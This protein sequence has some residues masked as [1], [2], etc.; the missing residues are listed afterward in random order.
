[1]RNEGTVI[2]SFVLPHLRRLVSF[3]V[4]FLFCLTDRKLLRLPQSRR[5]WLPR[6]LLA[7]WGGAVEYGTW[8]VLGTGKDVWGK[9]MGCQ[10]GFLFLCATDYILF[11][12]FPW[13]LRFSF[14][15]SAVRRRFKD[16]TFILKSPIFICGRIKNTAV[17]FF[18]FFCVCS[19]QNIFFIF[20]C[21]T[22]TGC[23]RRKVLLVTRF[24][25]NE[26]R[27]GVWSRIIYCAMHSK[28]PSQAIV[29][30]LAKFLIYGG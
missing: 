1:M 29:L 14:L 11:L 26:H 10:N 6:F 24:D 28:D 8:A 4:L 15:N 30:A 16:D 17:C 13:V 23:T 27:T 25:L 22:V 21:S 12:L 7:L 9:K 20:F 18:P 3:F 5:R 2:F 19:W